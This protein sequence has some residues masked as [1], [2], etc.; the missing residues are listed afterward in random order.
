MNERVFRLASAVPILMLLCVTFFLVGGPG[1]SDIAGRGADLLPHNTMFYVEVSGP[2]VIALLSRGQLPPAAQII[3]ELGMGRGRLLT[4]SLELAD[5]AL[6]LTTG[7]TSAALQGLRSV[8]FALIGQQP[9]PVL[10]V[11]LDS[12]ATV[13]Q[14]LAAGRGGAGAGPGGIVPIGGNGAA[15]AGREN[16]LLVGPSPEALRGMLELQ[17]GGPL[18]LGAQEPFQKAESRTRSRSPF[19]CHLNVR[20]LREA[21]LASAPRD[22]ARVA[23]AL[24]LDAVDYVTFASLGTQ[25]SPVLELFAGLSGTAGRLRRLIQPGR[26]LRI[27]ERVPADA[28][29]SVAFSLGD[30]TELW[31][32]FLRLMAELEQIGP[33]GFAEGMRQ[34]EEE[35]GLSIQTDLV[36]ALN[37]DM[38]AFITPVGNLAHYNNVTVLV[39]LSDPQKMQTAISKLEQTMPPQMLRSSSVQG[40]EVHAAGPV[41]WF[42]HGDMLVFVASET[43]LESYLD[44]VGGMPAIN[45][46]DAC[47]LL[48][49]AREAGN[50]ALTFNLGYLMSPFRA[51]NPPGSSEMDMFQTMLVTMLD[52]GLQCTISGEGGPPGI[53]AP[54][55]SIGAAA[56]MAGM[57][58]PALG[59]AR[60]SARGAASVSYL[61]QI[62]LACLMYANDHDGTLPNE[63]GELVPDYLSSPDVLVSPSD[64]SPMPLADT[65]LRTSYLYVGS[66]PVTDVD[67][68]SGVVMAYSRR[69]VH[70]ERTVLFADGH[71]E[72]LSEQRFRARLDESYRMVKETISGLSPERR[73]RVAR[74]YQGAE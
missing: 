21:A 13:R 4:D 46:T 64:P 27:L 70:R 56:L 11:Q 8:H 17:S 53:L 7:A 38:A 37:G 30:V 28:Y 54:R 12:E 29:A 43:A 69:G 49:P 68:P 67:R 65:G 24:N 50:V 10:V 72:T 59:R 42:I 35:L 41:S 61:R 1:G 60:S 57:L 34:A 25:E 39:G 26:Q 71:V 73:A 74:F 47:D 14:V 63:L 22:A 3:Q 40:L 18:S 55:Q 44:R 36:A 2:E 16:C 5:Q 48:A 52:E 58:M 15:M 31:G 20:A 19:W 33:T 51:D 9:V 62:G 23:N 32:E 6:G 45:I 66:L